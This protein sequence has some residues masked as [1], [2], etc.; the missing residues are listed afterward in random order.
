[1][2]INTSP[3]YA[4]PGV[5]VKTQYV[6]PTTGQSVTVNPDTDI[7]LVDPAGTLATLTIVLPTGQDGKK[8]KIASAQILT[9]LTVTGTIVGTLTTLALAGFAEFV[10]SSTAAKWFRSG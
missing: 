5:P 8:V 1:M 4:L 10:Y 9:A 7:L 3:S 6:T 2:D